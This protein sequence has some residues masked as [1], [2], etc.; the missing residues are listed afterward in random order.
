MNMIVGKK[1]LVLASLVVALG[2]AGF[3][4]N[5]FGGGGVGVGGEVG[6]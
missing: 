2:V 5:Q 1:Q 6:D 4:K 3:L